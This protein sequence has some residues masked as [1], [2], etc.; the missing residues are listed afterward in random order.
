MME[1]RQFPEA[2]DNLQ[3]A[4]LIYQA[5]GSVAMEGTSQARKS[6]NIPGRTNLA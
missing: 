2:L 6:Q 3:A 1:T 5:I 4:L